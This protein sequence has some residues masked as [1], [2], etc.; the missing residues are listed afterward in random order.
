M[1]TVKSARL[2]YGH[3][4]VELPADA[5]LIGFDCGDVFYSTLGDK[6]V[7]DAELMVITTGDGFDDSGVE[8]VDLVGV[9]RGLACVRIFRE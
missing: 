6:D 3:N 8:E 2:S 7:I 5:E 9:S 1:L 4:M